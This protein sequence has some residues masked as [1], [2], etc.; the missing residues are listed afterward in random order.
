MEETL[1]LKNL[2]FW[3][4]IQIWTSCQS[5]VTNPKRYMSWI[6][7]TIKFYNYADW[8]IFSKILREN[9]KRS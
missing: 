6:N 7:I 3:F 9:R 4:K 5:L 1:G 8:N 2:N